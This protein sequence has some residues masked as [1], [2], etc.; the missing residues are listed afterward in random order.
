MN[1]RTF[2]KTASLAT[3]AVTLPNILRSQGAGGRSPN[4]KLNIAC[5][6]VGG[7]GYEGAV[8]SLKGEN[9]VAFC[10][11]DDARAAK[12]FAEYPGVPRFRDFRV[13]LDKMD[14]E[15]DAVAV[16]V[17]DHMHFPI[18][19]AAIARGKHVF[20]EKPLT[21]TVAEARQLAQAARAKGVATQMGNQGHAMD[22]MRM[23]KEWIDAGVLGEVRE[24]QSWTDQPEWPQGLN[25]PD[26]SRMMPVEP[27][28][29][30]WD[31]WLG[32]AQPREYDPA[33]LP[34]VWRGFWDFGTG[35]LGDMGCHV[36]DGA[37]WALGLTTPTSVEATSA[38]LT[39]IS[40]PTATVV[41]FD[42][43]A[44]GKMAP[45]RWT[46]HDG[47]MMPPLPPELEE[48][49]K[50]PEDGTIIF[51]SKATVVADVFYESIRIVPEAKM[52]EQVAGLPP[53][54]LPR[55]AGGHF[56]EWVRACKGGAPAG[57]NFD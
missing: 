15:I 42:F 49:R 7:R 19:M 27:P 48:G 2:L 54:T 20:V 30:D 45:V 56:A 38:N 10:D 23:L 53:K 37:Y 55:V 4:N 31:L 14:K 33:Y 44:R 11:V 41:R 51:G 9:F 50:L 47:M 8:Q 24:L 52:K 36:M 26:H 46:W 34:F 28:A 22:G 43:P 12:A 17:P 13:M 1:R 3:A 6:G 21:H 5:C 39:E 32:V 18:A 25:P 29:L 16:A 40:A 35:S 57:S